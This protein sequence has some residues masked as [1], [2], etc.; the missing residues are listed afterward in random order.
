MN[1]NK[2]KL[3]FFFTNKKY[4]AIIWCV[5]SVLIAFKQ[6]LRD[7]YNNY[8]IFKNVFWHLM[9]IKNLYLHYPNEYFDRNHYGPFFSIIIAPFALLP[10]ILGGVVLNLALV[11]LF[12]YAIFQ[13]NID[14]KYKAILMW[15]ITNELITSLL[16]FQF[17]IY[18]VS[19]LI[20]SFA[21]ITSQKEIKAAWLISI[22]FLIKLYGIVGMSFLFFTKNRAKLVLS[23]G[24]TT[25]ILMFLPALISNFDFVYQ[26]YIDWFNALAIKNEANKVLGNMQDISVF[27]LI[28]RIFNLPNLSNL[29][30]II[31][32]FIIYSLSYFQYKNF[33]NP[34]FQLLF[35]CSTLIFTVI[36]STGAESPTYIIAYTGV[37]LWYLLLNNR[38]H[39]FY[40]FLFILSVFLTTLSPTDIFP[41]FIREEYII[42]YSLKALPCF[43]I[44]LVIQYQLIFFHKSKFESK[45]II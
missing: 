15:I 9:D 22:G 1:V 27:G 14:D 7:R 37:G 34:T 40:M 19:C 5:L 3:A 30:I 16:S 13:L 11:S 42:K 29:I 44:W 21:Y 39:K 4:V 38:Y 6:I 36:F 20:L 31:P 23:F 8:K 45:I 43:L 12:I 41:K 17:N 10:D 35:L 28:K 32:A 26:S 33:K 18:I 2:E 24:A 25:I